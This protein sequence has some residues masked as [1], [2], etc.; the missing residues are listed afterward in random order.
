ML[1]LAGGDNEI[2]ELSMLKKIFIVFFFLV[3]TT[4]LF[5]EFLFDGLFPIPA[6]YIVG[7][8]YPWRDEVWLGRIAFPVKNCEIRDVVRQLYPWRLFSIEE[9]KKGEFPL[10][11]P[12]NF[13]G[14]PHLANIFTACLYPLNAL[15]FILPFPLGWG[16]YIFLQ[17][18]LVGL[19]TFIFL[20]NLKLKDL[21]AL[22][23]SIVFT[24]SSFLMMR[25]EFGM[26]GHTA[27]WLPLALLAVDKLFQEKKFRWLLLAV[28]ALAFNFLAGYLQV[29]VYTYLIFLIYGFYRFYQ[30]K[31]KIAL[32]LVIIS[33]ILA[34][35][36]A[37]AQVLPLLE[38]ITK[39]SRIANYGEEDFFAGQFFLPWERLITFLV[40]DFF[41]NPVTWNFWGKVSYYEF[42]GY[43][44]VVSIFFIFYSFFYILRKKDV[45]FWWLVTGFGFLFLLPTPFARLPY[46]L[47]VPGFSALVPARVIF[48]INFSMAVLAAFGFEYFRREKSKRRLESLSFKT[49]SLLLFGFALVTISLLFGF[50]FWPRWQ[51]HASVAFFNMILPLG[52]LFAALLVLSF[53]FAF[54]SQKLRHLLLFFLVL[55]LSFDLLHNARKYNSF[56]P[57]EIVFP[58]TEAI[59]FLKKQS[60]ER[61]RVLV[62]HPELLTPSFN[63]PY[64]IEM[65]DGYDSFHSKRTEELMMA[66]NS[67]DPEG[68][69]RSSGRSTFSTNYRSPLFDLMNAKYVL[70]LEEVDHPKL[71]LVF[72]KGLTRI[73]Q[74]LNSYPRAYLTND[75]V[76]LND[77]EEILAEMLRFSQKGEKRA[78]LEKEVEIDTGQIKPSQAGIEIKEYTPQK[79]E[80][81]TESPQKA[82]LVLSD[83]Y[84]PGWKALIDEQK[85]ELYRANYNFRAVVVPA[86]QHVVQ[87]V[88]RPRLFRVGLYLSAGSLFLIM[89]AMV[90]AR[91]R[92]IPW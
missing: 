71:K 60:G 74:N 57:P 65:V 64:G 55:L 56:N 85:A 68:R 39:S 89:I 50:L 41:G 32:L 82:I 15:F 78:V 59:E 30:K 27:L 92:K 48:V 12:Y 25:L 42:T 4:F 47:G 14:T 20:K 40:P 23:G 1:S 91:S 62:T 49:T 80:I 79:V 18:L 58:S 21:A 29:T 11:N 88:Y 87:F 75:F 19:T 86:G 6:D 52:V 31:D 45:L 46:T 13:T 36:L 16:I 54:K 81:I 35:L 51:D 10:W 61:F 69:F 76:V 38:T 28:L 83:A 2:G 84:D 3:L 7:G 90:V 72:Q 22:F 43:I 53:Y 5:K 26:V 44:G 73:Y 70:T 9:F 66:A 77:D 63:I 67:E 33:P 37:G 34:F 8:Y 17:P 24:F